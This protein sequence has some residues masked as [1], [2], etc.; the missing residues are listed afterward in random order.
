MQKLPKDKSHYCTLYIVRHG[1][2]EWNLNR[3]IQGHVDSP[4]TSEGVMQ[5]RAL[6][7][8]FKD[9][10]F[11]AAYSSDLLRAHRTAELISKEKNLIIKTS[12]HLRERF[13][14]KLEGRPFND[15]V[16]ELKYVFEEYIDEQEKTLLESQINKE[17]VK[18]VEPIKNIIARFIPFIREIAITHVGEKVLV[19]SH[20]GVLLR[21]IKHLGY[22]KNP[23]IKNTG[24]IKILCDGVDFFVEEVQNI[25]ES[26]F[27]S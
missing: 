8:K 7:K 16:N 15:H 17:L 4:L 19:V 18:D 27:A 3:I 21:F 6:G 20:G 12:E 14:G 24:Y 26:R 11:T 23:Y 10:K 22:M 9:I 5:A 2:T 25:E 1:Q 13:L